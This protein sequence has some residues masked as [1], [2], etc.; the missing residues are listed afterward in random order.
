MALDQKFDE[1]KETGKLK[2]YMQ[3]KRVQ[4]AKK[5]HRWMPASREEAE[6]A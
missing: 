3:K 2:A 4:N 1:L 5:D 6:E